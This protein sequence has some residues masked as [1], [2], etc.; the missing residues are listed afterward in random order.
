[1]V[2]TQALYDDGILTITRTPDGLALAGQIV[3]STRA[4]L[5]DALNKLIEHDD[6]VHVHLSGVRSCDAAGL[7]I[8]V[9]LVSPSGMVYPCSAG[10]YEPARH[11]T[12]HGLPRDLRILLHVLGWETLPGLMVTD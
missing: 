1:M 8:I 3:R 6:D 5:T 10:D 4:P 11:V 12:L 7:G 2:N 9:G